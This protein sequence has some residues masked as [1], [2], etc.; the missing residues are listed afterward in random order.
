MKLEKVAIAKEYEVVARSILLAKDTLPPQ[1]TSHAHSPMN[2]LKRFIGETFEQPKQATGFEHKKRAIGEV[3]FST[4]TLQDPH[5]QQII[6][7]IAQRAGVPETD[8]MTAINRDIQDMTKNAGLAPILYETMIKN[9]AESAAFSV[10]WRAHIPLTKKDAL[11]AATNQAMGGPVI[12][13]I[14]IEDPTPIGPKFRRFW[15]NQLVLSVK[16]EIP[17]LF[18]LRGF[19]DRRAQLNIKTVFVPDPDLPKTPRYM[20]ETACATPGAEF[21]FNEVFMQCLIDYATIKQVKPKSAKY[22]CNGGNIPD[23]YA[24]IEFIILHEFMHFTHEDFYYQTIIPEANPTIINY[25]GDFRSNYMLVKS[26]YEQLPIG[27]FNDHVNYD[28]QVEYVQMYNLVKEELAKLTPKDREDIENE[29]D[30]QSDDHEPGQE[31]GRESPGEG[32]GKG[33]KYIPKVGDKVKLPD[34]SPGIVRSVSGERAE[35]DRL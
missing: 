1:V 9:A 16:A 31:E 13:I 14:K 34:G 2:L 33:K 32:Q 4:S 15:F 22:V 20:I 29:L 7:I 21:V 23:A 12:P 28:R 24:Y 3:Q 19:V 10:F 11:I 27:L 18:P 6:A 25:V 17:N 8:V 5:I 26:G 35:V 30:G